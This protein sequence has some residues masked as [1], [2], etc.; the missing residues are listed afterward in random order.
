MDL[1]KILGSLITSGALTKGSNSDIL[2]S[3]IGA[4][5]GGS[6][7]QQTQGGSTIG[8]ILGSLVGGGQS[9]SSSGG[10]IRDILGSLIGGGKSSSTSSGLGDI[11]G[12]LIG[13]GSSNSSS[14]GALGDILGSLVGGATPTHQPRGSTNIPN[15]KDL[16]DI[17]GIGK[18]NSAGGLGGLIAS[19]IAKHAQHNNPNVPTPANDDY[20]VLP[21]GLDK[22]DADKRAELIIRAM[23]NAA[24]AD[25]SID[26]DEQN[27]IIAKLGDLTQEEIDFVKREFAAPLDV[28]AFARTVPADMA[29][30]IY[31]VSL[32][33]IDLDK[34]SE[35][36]YLANLAKA[37]SI[38]THVANKIHEKLG[39]PK[40]FA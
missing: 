23:I 25:G 29:E 33:A 6:S 2:G 31:T 30:Q 11:L 19:S 34:N 15:A 21:I 9:N 37:L 32:T 3:L 12:S 35:A 4:A 20:S 22:A 26:Q 7:N 38:P 40:I 8:D 36:Q 5:L 18:G 14:G 17:L 27:R 28:E 39:V 16:E 24:K 1:T 13:G 10:A